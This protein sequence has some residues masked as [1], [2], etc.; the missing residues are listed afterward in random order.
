MFE[1]VPGQVTNACKGQKQVWLEWIM[2]WVRGEFRP[3]LKSEETRPLVSLHR[4]FQNVHDRNML[5]PKQEERGSYHCIE[6]IAGALPFESSY[7]S[8]VC[9]WSAMTHMR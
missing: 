3:R 6:L 7:D 2:L 4:T 5:A 8:F 1:K 9:C